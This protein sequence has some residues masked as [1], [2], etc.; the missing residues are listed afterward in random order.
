VPEFSAG[1]S[2]PETVPVILP[3]C[4]LQFKTFVDRIVGLAATRRGALRCAKP[5]RRG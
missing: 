1:S 4:N 2:F 5:P 3:D